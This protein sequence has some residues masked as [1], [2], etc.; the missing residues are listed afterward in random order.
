M[1]YGVL[2]GC[3][4]GQEWLLPWFFS[5]FRA[6]NPTCPIAFVDFG[7]TK[8]TRSWCEERGAL[9]AVE[10]VPPAAD[11]SGFLFE[12]ERWI[13][14]PFTPSAMTL[15]QRLFFRKPLALLRSPFE[16]TLWL[17]LDCQV[18]ANLDPLFSLPLSSSGLA[19]APAGTF[20]FAKNLTQSK[21]FYLSKFN[22]GVVLIEKS[23]LLLQEWAALSR[24]PISFWTDEGSLAFVSN[25][26]QMPVKQM[27]KIYNWPVAWGANE[28][29]LVYH[30]IGE[31][32]KSDLKHLLNGMIQ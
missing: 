2:A 8:N 15:K 9:I 6:S 19:A 23:S 14:H 29:A 28:S 32:A 25:Q 18:R 10:D 13:E 7:M 11:A 5:R 24:G 4:Q 16:R 27:P 30:W 31:R 17:D 20:L 22:C 21:I 26:K 12:E 1:E 3:D